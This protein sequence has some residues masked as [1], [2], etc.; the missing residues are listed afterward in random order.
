M[1]DLSLAKAAVDD[2][3]VCQGD[4]IRD[5]AQGGPIKPNAALGKVGHDGMGGGGGGGLLY[6]W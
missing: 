5:E 2:Y 6:I 3:L 1:P 4:F